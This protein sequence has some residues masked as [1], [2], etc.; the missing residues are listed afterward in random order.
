MSN[1]TALNLFELRR[2]HARNG[3]RDTPTRMFEAHGRPACDAAGTTNLASC[4]HPC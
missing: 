2:D 3:L 4:P 1:E